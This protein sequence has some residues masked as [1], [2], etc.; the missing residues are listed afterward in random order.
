MRTDPIELYRLRDG[1]YAA[2]LL[3]AGVCWLDFF[4]WLAERPSDLDGICRGLELQQRP[5]DV[6]LTLFAALGLVRKERAVFC[7][8]ELAREHLVSSSPFYLG[9]YLAALKERAVCRDLL[10]VLRT[11][12]PASW[13]SVPN[14]AAWTR[15]MDDA[16]FADGFTAAMDARAAVLAPALA[17]Q[18]DCRGYRCLLDVAGG[19]GV[20]ACAIVAAHPELTATV[21]EKPPVDA[22]ARR[23][24]AERGLADRVSVLAGD[25]FSAQ[26]PAHCDVHLFS[27]VLHDWDVPDVKRLLARSFAALPPGGLLLIHDAHLDATKSGPLPVAQYSVLLMHATEGR[28]YSIAEMEDFLRECGAVDIRHAATAADRSVVS[29]KKAA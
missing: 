27:N 25:M 15:K 20:Y 12:R 26:L 3:V 17:R 29:A 1:I 4:T 28:C 21:L 6:M 18:V 13:C 7:V 24:I 11:G 2:D 8:T 5:A 23:R 22:L 10:A 9:P 14:D 19:S 16:E